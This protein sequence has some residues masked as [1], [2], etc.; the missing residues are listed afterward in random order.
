MRKRNLMLGM[1]L[2]ALSVS[3]SACGDK[4]TADKAVEETVDPDHTP[5]IPDN[6]RVP[7]ISIE[8]AEA[9]SPE[10]SF[11]EYKTA[12]EV[13]AESDEE[14][15][16][17]TKS[18][19]D[20]KKMQTIDGGRDIT[21]AE[22]R[23]FKYQMIGSADIT[24]GD[25]II[26]DA[27]DYIEINPELKS[28]SPEYTTNG[29]KL[30]ISVHDGRV[31]EYTCVGTGFVDSDILTEKIMLDLI[32]DNTSMDIENAFIDT[33]YTKFTDEDNPGIMFKMTTEGGKQVA[34]VYRAF[35]GL[36][37]GFFSGDKM[38]QGEQMWV[39]ACMMQ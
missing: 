6:E 19:K 33:A 35:N 37:V 10:L 39:Q 16:V 3:L 17:E 32:K 26:L 2:M 36:Y 18:E 22:I 13:Y 15:A 34:I 11:P 14:E 20:T 4:E 28:D 29:N 23:P 24:N 38:G 5:Y 25:D 1:C 9:W 21:I 7:E 30:T 31:A 12:D 27:Y 8:E